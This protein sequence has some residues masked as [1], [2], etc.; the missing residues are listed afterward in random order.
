VSR[1]ASGM[2]PN[3]AHALGYTGGVRSLETAHCG[4]CKEELEFDAGKFGQTIERCRNRRCVNH[5]WH[6]PM[7]DVFRAPELARR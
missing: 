2:Q 3:V 4:V 6:A 1:G 5:V 7:R